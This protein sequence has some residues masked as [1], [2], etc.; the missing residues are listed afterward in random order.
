M[1]QGRLNTSQFSIVIA[2]VTFGTDIL[3]IPRTVANGAENSGW[4]SLVLAWLVGAAA[5]ALLVRLAERFPDK[6]LTD[7]LRSSLADGLGSSWA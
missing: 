4:I 2:I 7:T 3:S 6:T 5:L 1:K